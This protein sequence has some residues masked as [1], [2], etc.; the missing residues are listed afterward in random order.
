MTPHRPRSL[1][2]LVGL[3]L[4][5]LF[6]ATAAGS[7]A[8]LEPWSVGERIEA[9]SLEDQHGT[10]RRVDEET[11]LVLFSRDMD[12]G[13][14]LERALREAPEGF[15]QS[16]GAVYVA[17]L[18]RMPALVT[19][20]VAL[21]RLRRR[22]YPMLL[23]R[24]GATTARLPGAEG[25]AT[26]I[27]LEDLRVTRVLHAASPE[28]VARALGLDEDPGSAGDATRGAAEEG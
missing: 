26:L 2:L 22:P 1:R 19:R 5:A 24:E 9:F 27:F 6:A 25:R 14:I 11:R 10:T 15:L 8:A 18:H 3:P 7:A 13:G 16:R 17:D 4:L 23:D 21:P 20:L 12:G 28:A